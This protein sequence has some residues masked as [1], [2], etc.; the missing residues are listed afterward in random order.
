M[1]RPTAVL[2]VLAASQVTPLC[3]GYVRRS[4]LHGAR[5]WVFVWVVISAV[6]NLIGWAMGRMHVNNHLITYVF[7]PL[8]GAAILWALSLW[9]TRP[10]AVLTTRIAIP[11]FL[12]AWALAV[13]FVESAS[14]FSMFAEPIYSMLALGAAAY[15]LVS[16]SGDTVDPLPQ[17][18]WFWICGGLSLYFAALT[19]LLPL[20]ATLV[21]SR[22][23]I[24]VRAYNVHALVTTP[25]FLCIA[26]GFLCQASKPTLSGSISSP[27]SSV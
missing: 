10:L 8:Q 19:V 18:D 23:D 13:L 3:T 12:V 21:Y 25:A 14:N 7:T 26:I 22:P 5:F 4:Q 24:V 2:Y 6:M 11:C 27:A 20:A 16:R 1:A 15:T 17:Q 9:Q